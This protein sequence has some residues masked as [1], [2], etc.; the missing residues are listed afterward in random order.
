M[1][2]KENSPC[3]K[4]RFTKRIDSLFNYFTKEAVASWQ[5]CR[6]PQ[7]ITPVFL[8]GFPRSGTTLLDTILRTH[9]KVTVVEEKPMVDKVV[10][11]LSEIST[12]VIH[13]NDQQCEQLRNIYY[14]ELDKHIDHQDGQHII[15]DKMPL[16][17]IYVGI[18]KK[19]FPSAKFILVLRHPNDSVLSCF[20]QI[21]AMNDAMANFSN[22]QDSA[23]FYHKV[24]LL[25]DRYQSV[26]DLNVHTIKY[27]EI[28]DNYEQALKPLLSF[29][30]LPWD[31]AMRNYKETA[32][33]RG[34]IN[35]PSYNQVTKPL[36]KSAQGR[37]KHYE[38]QMTDSF[39][40]L[41]PWCDYF[42]YEKE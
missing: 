30:D 22:L 4:T 40:V 39:P 21:F 33:K 35:T 10:N 6:K 36:Y 12:D 34:N 9:S 13:M 17:I 1:Q 15:I 20:M 16:N 27:E 25:W 42:D 5:E 8:I 23:S 38:K 37:W 7:G 2:L 26:F 11:A 19:I 29:L 32:L 14:E 28:I 24:M 3:D 41:S 31:D 18:I